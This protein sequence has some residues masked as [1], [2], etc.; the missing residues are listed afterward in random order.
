M[1]YR[2]DAVRAAIKEWKEHPDGRPGLY[3]S[4]VL[5]PPDPGYNGDWCGGFVLRNLKQ[6]GL[7]KDVPWIIGEGFIWPQRLPQTS[8]PQPGDV[9][10]VP[11][12]FGHQAMVVVY[13][14]VTGMVTS[15]DGNQPGIAPKVRFV[16][17]G[18]IEFY[19]IQPFVD[20]AER[21]APVWP[22][23]LG[24]A[25]LLGAAAWVWLNGVPAPIERGLRRL[26]V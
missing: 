20:E 3:W 15:I 16:K 12:P 22:Y 25:A 26:G 11:E 5:N 23:L 14:P 6:A 8:N 1:S 4:E 9:V 7:A 13:E 21:N 17:N 24:G 10:Y 18:N 19:S 2:S